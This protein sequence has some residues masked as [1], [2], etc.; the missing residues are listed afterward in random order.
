MYGAALGP[1]SILRATNSVE[2]KK[3]QSE[4]GTA[5][6]LF[7]LQSRCAGIDQFQGDL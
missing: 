1:N 4:R 3:S 6:A 7:T 5:A 2:N